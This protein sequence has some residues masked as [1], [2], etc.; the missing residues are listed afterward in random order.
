MAEILIDIHVKKLIHTSNGNELLDLRFTVPQNGFVT[1]FGKSGVGKT[2]LLRMI[3]GLTNPDFGYIKVN[4]EVWF[5]SEKKINLKTQ[6]RSLGFV[7]Q[8]YALFPNMTVKEHL[9]YAQ[10]TK[11]TKYIS[12]LLEIFHLKGLCNRKPM[13]LSGGQQQRL[14][15]ARALA[16]KPQIL[17]LD[18]P[19]SALDNETRIN[20]QHEILQAHEAISAT[21]LLVSHDINEVVK[22]SDHVYV[23]ENGKIAK[24]G[25]PEAVFNTEKLHA[26]FQIEAK[27]LK[28]EHTI[29]TIST[30]NNIT[31][32]EVSVEEAKNLKIND[33]ILITVNAVNP[34]FS[35]LN[36]NHSCT[37]KTE[38]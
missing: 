14:A 22:L 23:I 12:E 10:P 35:K 32:M 6:Q 17:L 37:V 34:T 33:E 9:L 27:I 1:F 36:I 25:S 29:L 8:D 24:E 31:T 13:K 11:E 2:T 5:D 21:T 28:I 26:E 3:A 38:D 4:N 18:E 19:L 15:V 30:N 7:F 16:R 20:L